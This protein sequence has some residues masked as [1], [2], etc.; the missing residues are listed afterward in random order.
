ML[1]VAHRSTAGE[2]QAPPLSARPKLL[3][4]LPADLLL[5]IIGLAA[6]PLSAWARLDVAAAQAAAQAAE[7]AATTAAAAA[8]EAQAA[9]DAQATA[10]AQE[11]DD[12]ADE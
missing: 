11:H 1:L 6:Y 10:W 2:E 7:A 4:R 12:E 3:G 8:T 9:A 5:R